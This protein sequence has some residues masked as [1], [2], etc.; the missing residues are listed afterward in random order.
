MAG[1]IAT[2]SGHT[3]FFAVISII[4][5]WALRIGLS[6]LFALILGYGSTGVYFAMTLSNIIAGLLSVIWVISKKWLKK[7]I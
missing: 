6:I 3:R 5:L 2:G 7:V 1:A 4:R